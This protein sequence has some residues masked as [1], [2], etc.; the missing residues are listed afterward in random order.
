MNLLRA[1]R[2]TAFPCKTLCGNGCIRVPRGCKH[3][4]CSAEASTAATLGW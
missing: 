2:V 3:Q 1:V 4:S